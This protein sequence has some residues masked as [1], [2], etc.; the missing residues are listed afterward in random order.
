MNGLK[1][2]APAG[3]GGLFKAKPL[4]RMLIVSE[5]QIK[6]KQNLPQAIPQIADGDFAANPLSAGWAGRVLC[7]RFARCSRAQ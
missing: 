4:N 2:M 3:G 6:F 1:W 7:R 5:L